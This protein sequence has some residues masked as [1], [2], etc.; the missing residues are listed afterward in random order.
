MKKWNPKIT[1][2][3]AFVD[4]YEREITA[5]ESVY[6]NV[7]VFLCD[8]HREQAWDRWVNKADHGVANVADQVK[9]C[10]RSITHSTL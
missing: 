9:V 3:Y 1:P 4:F 2:K 6:P 7:K 8:F 10:L 5:L